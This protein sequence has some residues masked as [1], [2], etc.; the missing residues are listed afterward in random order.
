MVAKCNRAAI[1]LRAITTLLLLS[2]SGIAIAQERELPIPPVR[3]PV[4]ERGVNLATGQVELASTDVTIG[5]GQAALSFTRNWL[6]SFTGAGWRHQYLATLNVHF[7]DTS[8]DVVIGETK[9]TFAKSGSVYTSDQNDGGTLVE[10][11][12]GWIYTTSDGTKYVFEPLVANASYYGDATAVVTSIIR[13]SGDRVTLDYKTVTYTETH[14]NGSSTIDVTMFVRRLQ[15]VRSSSGY[16]LK[17]YYASNNMASSTDADEWVRITDVKAINNAHEFCSP[18]DDGCTLTQN[19]PTATYARSG[20]QETV[21]DPNGRVTR[22]TYVGPVGWMSRIKAPRSASA[23]T[24]LFEYVDGRVSSVSNGQASWSYSWIW[25]NTTPVVTITDPLQHS[26]RVTTEITQGVITEVKDALNR[27]TSYNYDGSGRLTSQVMPGTGSVHYLR[28]SRGNVHTINRLNEAANQTISTYASYDATCSNPV[29]CNKPNTTTDA[30]GNVT[31][32]YYNPVH[33]GVTRVERPAPLASQARPET[34]FT[35]QQRS[36]VTRN[37]AGAL[38]TEPAVWRLTGTSSCITGG[39]GCVGTANELRTS[40]VYGATGV[41]NNL[42]ATSVSTGAGDGSLTATVGYGHDRFGNQTSVDGPLPGADDT[43]FVIY[44]MGREVTQVVSP[45]PDGPSPLLRRS[46]KYR[47]NDDGQVDVVTTGTSAADGSSFAE[48][49]RNETSY[50]GLGR[51][52]LEQ[53]V[54]AGVS[55]GFTQFSYDA[56]NRP[57]CVAQRM[58]RPMFGGQLDACLQGTQGNDGPDRIS[59]TTYYADDQVSTVLSGVGTGLLQTTQAFTYNATSG[60]VETVTDARGNKTTF[61]YDGFGRL[62][63]TFY[64]SAANGAVSS[65]GD[66]EQLLYD[67]NGRSLVTS[68]RVRDG[69]MIHLQYDALG[70]L[71]FR[72]SP[73]AAGETDVTYGYDN[74]DRLVEATDQMGFRIGLNR[75]ALGRVTEETNSQGLGSIY[76]GYDLAGRRTTQTWA[77]GHVI[78]YDHLVTGELWRVRGSDPNVGFA[79]LGI[80]AYDDLG[81]RKRLDRYNGTSTT[82]SYGSGP[83]LT[84][85][86]HLRG[87]AVELT[88]SF[89]LVSAVGEIRQATSSNTAFSYGGFVLTDRSYATANG[90]NQYPSDS[91]IGGTSATFGYDGRGNLTGSTDAKGVT[92]YGYSADNRLVTFN[93]QS[94]VSSLLTRQSALGYDPLDRLYALTSKNSAGQVTDDR[95]LRYGADGELIGEQAVTGAWLKRYV[96]GAGT[97]EPLMWYEGGGTNDRRWFHADERGSIVAVTGGAGTV[98]ER[99]SY[100]EH[101]I[102]GPNNG[103]QRF[104]YTGQTW[105]SEI[106]A[107]NYKA[108]IY[109]PTL[110]RFLQPDPIGYGD[111]MNLYAYV[112]GDRSWDGSERTLRRGISERR[113]DRAQVRQRVRLCACSSSARTDIIVIASS[114]APF[115][116]SGDLNIESA[117]PSFIGSLARLAP[118]ARRPLQV[119]SRKIQSRR[120]ILPAQLLRRRKDRWLTKPQAQR[121]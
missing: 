8:A 101:G 21:T 68:V 83:W 51:K 19:W 3:S 20:N 81:R 118:A 42:Y 39:P 30:G 49:Q 26:T 33:G 37:A 91:N 108:R 104:Q 93:H 48:L 32:Y 75:D 46:V 106:G 6:Q 115:R 36:A 28:D 110:G 7:S 73:N 45:D 103:N 31:N 50:D 107:Y 12:G 64:P 59:Q 54:M 14:H 88:R 85:L 80:Y 100:D 56:A 70:R 87:T 67:P 47:R 98:L 76:Y 120:M 90:L 53:M 119:D 57:L 61:E 23:D 74:L 29:T 44:N 72:D 17:L 18:Q 71:R 97:D 10:S 116:L 113:H 82:W 5:N 89:P 65:T 11:N 34:R 117:I 102:P 99:L 25:G 112:G 38:V 2:T 96:H 40:I 43:S 114:F 58:N 63:K 4:D 79:A 78:L 66:Y 105:L 121:S 9:R 27:V 60:K 22:Y 84:E 109:S 13:P 86:S 69:Q 62:S 94:Y 111:G 35:Y 24:T 16:Q 77:D 92:S 52:T 55:Y 95:R 41:A 1:G 15:S